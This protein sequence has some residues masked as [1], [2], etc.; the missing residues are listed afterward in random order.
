METIYRVAIK[1][2]YNEA[3]FDFD[4]ANDAAEFARR[5]VGHS[6]SSDDQSKQTKIVMW[7]FNKDA[8]NEE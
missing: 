6:V 5:A 1:V 7:V 2:G 8:E 3:H 4:N